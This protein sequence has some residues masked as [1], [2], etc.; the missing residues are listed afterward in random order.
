MAGELRQ[1]RH[2][3]SQ[4]LR[5]P[6]PVRATALLQQRL[7]QRAH[8]PVLGIHR[9][10]GTQQPRDGADRRIE[11]EAAAARVRQRGRA[12]F[13]LHLT[14]RGLQQPEGRR[15][16]AAA[17]E[18]VGQP[19]AVFP[20]ELR[21]QPEQLV[22]RRAVAQTRA[23]QIVHRHQ[24]VAQPNVVAVVPDRDRRGDRPPLRERAL[25]IAADAGQHRVVHRETGR[26]G[27]EQHGAGVGGEPRRGPVGRAPEADPAVRPLAAGEGGDDTLEIR[28]GTPR[29]GRIGAQ[30]GARPVERDE[31][32]GGAGDLLAAPVRV[33][34]EALV[35]AAD[36][37]Q[38]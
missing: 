18:H 38:W 31:R 3:G 35:H 16:V 14:P 2:R 37:R 9:E 1:R 21:D 7:D 4:V 13:D 34:A 5:V 20:R 28:A 12:A 8:E 27:L 32:L 30:L 26:L 29:D 15:A 36:Q 10:G 11:V 6:H 33:D 25:E 22:L 19:D 24:P 17:G 23:A